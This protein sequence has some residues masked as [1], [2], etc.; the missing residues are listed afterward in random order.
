VSDRYSQTEPIYKQVESLMTENIASGKWPLHAKLLDEITLAEELRVSRGTLRKAIKALIDKGLLVQLRG[1]GTFVTSNSIDQPLASRLISFSEAMEEQSLNYVTK[2]LRAEKIKPDLKVQALLEIPD[3]EDVILIERV[4]LVGGYPIIYLKNYVPY[5]VCPQL[6]G[7][8]FEKR[9]LFD[10]L[11]N[12]YHKKL[13][14]GRRY[15]KAVAALGDVAFHL[16]LNPGAPV[17]HLEQIAYTDQ[18]RPVEY[19]AVWIESEK[20]SVSAILK[21]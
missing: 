11:E 6:L 17:M 13:S 5:G 12:K 18:N 15:F 9:T 4:R 2:V 10:L 14:W 21:R 16:G 7:E 19:S 8:D 3:G 1:K 20:M